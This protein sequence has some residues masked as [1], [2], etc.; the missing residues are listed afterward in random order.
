[1]MKTGSRGGVLTLRGEV[2]GQRWVE[3]K[4]YGSDFHTRAVTTLI[5]S[6][7]V[8]SISLSRSI[9]VNLSKVC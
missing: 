7:T 4:R 9:R 3:E 8:T 5:L 2:K 1:M 6:S